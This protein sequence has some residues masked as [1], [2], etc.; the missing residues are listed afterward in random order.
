MIELDEMKLIY[1]LKTIII[2]KPGYK[3]IQIDS[4]GYQKNYRHN[5]SN[6]VNGSQFHQWI[7]ILKIVIKKMNNKYL[8]GKLKVCLLSI[9]SLLL[10][11][12]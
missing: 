7:K 2:I 6:I 8:T 9:E 11:G 1:H 4:R 12:R 10:L 5:L 3:L